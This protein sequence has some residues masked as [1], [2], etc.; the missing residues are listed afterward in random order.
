VPYR[1]RVG[2]AVPTVNRAYYHAPPVD[3]YVTF[4]FPF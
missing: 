4:G 1:L 2:M 3:F